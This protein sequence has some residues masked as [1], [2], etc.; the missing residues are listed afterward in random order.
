[1]YSAADSLRLHRAS[2]EFIGRILDEPFDGPTVIVTHHLPSM[3]SVH[4][5]YRKDPVSAGFASC[6]D[7]LVGKGAAL[8]VHG[9]THFSRSWRAA[10]GTLVLCNPAGYASG[11][12]GSWRRENRDFDPRLVVDIRRGG[13]DRAWKAGVVRG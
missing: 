6:C 10:N 5:I 9:H 11:G 4:G 7:D 12:V 13:P 1:V 3:K 8:W 2:R